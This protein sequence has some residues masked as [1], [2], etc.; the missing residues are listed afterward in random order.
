[1]NQYAAEQIALVATLT[2]ARKRTR[3]WKFIAGCVVVAAL[4]HQFSGSV[5]VPPAVTQGVVRLQQAAVQV[6]P[7]ATPVQQP[8]AAQ[9]E[10]VPPPRTATSVEPTAEDQRREAAAAARARKRYEAEE[11]R[12]QQPPAPQ[13][14]QRG[15]QP[16]RV[17]PPSS[18]PSPSQPGQGVGLGTILMTAAQAA[19][20]AEQIERGRFSPSRELTRAARRAERAERRRQRAERRRTGQW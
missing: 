17:V 8:A 7:T 10:P 4:A 16:E 1:M 15:A 12:M 6:A 11:R 5:Q 18:R 19:R 13:P 9:P 20:V 2:Q 3:R 14:P